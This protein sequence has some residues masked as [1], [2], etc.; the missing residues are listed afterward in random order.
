MKRARPLLWLIA[1]LDLLGVLL[2]ALLGVR[3]RH[4]DLTLVLQPGGVLFAGG[5][6]FL[7]WFFGAYSFLRWPWMPYRQLAQR[8]VL[9]VSSALA[10][11]VAVG[12]LLNSP[13]TAIWF[14]RSTLAILAV[15]SFS[16]G[17]LHR[18]WLQPIARRQAARRLAASPIA[19]E[20]QPRAGRQDPQPQRRQRELLL[21]IV[22]YHPSRLEVEQ[23]Q[24]CL[25]QLSP[26]IGYA[27]VVNDH[28]PGEPID[29][30]ASGADCF[31]ANRDNPGYG[32]AINRLVVRLERLPEFIGVLNTDLSWQPNS[33]ECLLAWL[34]DHPGVNLAVPR[35]I[36]ESGRTSQLCKQNP[37]LLGLLSRRFLPEWLKPTWLKQYDRWFVMA[38]HNYDDII[39]STYLS[40]CCMLIRSESFRK[41][42]GFDERYFLYLE[43][44]DLSRTLAI[45]GD[46]VHLPIASIVH[47][48]GRGSYRNLDLM[49]VNVTSAWHYFRKWGWSLW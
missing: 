29:Q 12:W 27:V 34:K 25:D 23:L 18:L 28:V 7:A 37:T 5:F 42:G 9:L 45:D 24:A 26:E 30:L 39:R 46:C 15:V 31:L 6:L 3:L 1:S 11:A 49:M 36:E 43:D 10:L 2:G 22:A 47:G 14:H 38:D 48:W 33:F 40:G 13:P 35:I 21:L 41:A 17:L 32:R 19:R 20:Q 4:D 44:A 16:W 8:Y